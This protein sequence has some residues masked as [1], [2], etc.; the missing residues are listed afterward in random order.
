[1]PA[2]T[3]ISNGA[4]VRSARSKNI[5]YYTNGNNVYAHNVLANGTFPTAP[6]FSVSNSTENIVDMVF[7]DDDNL[8]YIATND[9]SNAMQGSLYCYD[10]QTNA[11]RWSKQHITKK[12]VKALYRNK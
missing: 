12:I 2:S 3:G 4:I 7:S 10:T 5:V 9:S 1:M 8:I 11:L 6:L